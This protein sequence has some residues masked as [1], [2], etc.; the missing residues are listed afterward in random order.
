MTVGSKITF[1]KYTD[2]DI[3][4]VPDEAKASLFIEQETTE[5]RV[6]VIVATENEVS[7]AGDLV[8]LADV[9]MINDLE[10][11]LGSMQ[12]SMGA[13]PLLG[14]HGAY[15]VNNIGE[16]LPATGAFKSDEGIVSAM[17]F[18]QMLMSFL[19]FKFEA[20]VFPGTGTPVFTLDDFSSDVN[21]IAIDFT[22]PSS[23]IRTLK[24][25]AGLMTMPFYLILADISDPTDEFEL[26]FDSDN[27]GATHT[28]TINE[29][30][31][32]LILKMQANI[33]DFDLVS[34]PVGSTGNIMTPMLSVIKISDNFD[35]LNFFPT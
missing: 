7:G 15:I 14:Y 6:R 35:F 11:N 27:G 4:S 16:D 1:T 30:G 34:D 5:S 19:K 25:N 20:A 17:P 2:G 31:V 33:P 3:A 13:N 8:Y 10:T 21:C 28:K 23:I 24:L 9:D 22:S 12:E 32:Y 26:M 29:R 18:I